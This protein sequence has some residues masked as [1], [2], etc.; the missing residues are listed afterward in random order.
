MKRTPGVQRGD[1]HV[2]KGSAEKLARP[3]GS[4]KTEHNDVSASGNA[5]H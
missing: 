2:I 4:G 1:E 3:G 5:A